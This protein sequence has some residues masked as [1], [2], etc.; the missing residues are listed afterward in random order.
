MEECEGLKDELSGDLRRI[1]DIAGIEAAVKIGRAFKGT[2]LYIR[3][4]DGLLRILRDV[5]IKADYDKGVGIRRLSRRY[6]LTERQ[7]RNILASEE[8]GSL[9]EDIERLLGGKL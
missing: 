3:G 1:A 9:P 4:I 5:N 6:N 7:I 2:Y 8:R